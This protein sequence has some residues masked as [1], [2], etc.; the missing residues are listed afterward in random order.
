MSSLG[1]EGSVIRVVVD[2]YDT[3]NDFINILYGRVKSNSNF[4]NKKW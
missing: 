3:K 2:E 1:L 4:K